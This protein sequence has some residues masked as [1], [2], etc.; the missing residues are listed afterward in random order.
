MRLTTA[1]LWDPAPGTLLRW[2]VH[3]DGPGVPATLS[4]NQRNHLSAAGAGAPSVWLA[5]AFDVDGPIDPVAL[6]RALQAFV[7]R[8]GS[9]QLEA[10]PAD[11]GAGA[12]RHDPDT[13]RWTPVDG[14]ATTTV[15]QT[16][17]LLGDV[18][19]AGCHPFGH[20]AFVPAA[21][22]RA[23]RSTIV[24]GMDHLHC[25]AYSLTIVVEELSAL[26]DAH[27]RGTPVE[28]PQAACVPAD[29]GR[30]ARTPV[31]TDRDRLARWHDAL[32]RNEFRLPTFPL[33]LGVAPGERLAQAT[34]VRPLADAGVT[35][36]LSARARA[37]GAS[38]Y[39]VC[40]VALAAALREA[41]GP[42]RLET[43]A[44]AHTR[45]DPAMRRAVG[46]YTT[47]VPIGVGSE[48]TEETIAAA[49]AAVREAV[50]LAA[51]PLDRVL[52]SV[53]QPLVQTRADVFMV[54]WLD[55]RHLPGAELAGRRNA[56]HV[57]ATTLADDVQ[58]WLAR[59]ADGVAVRA[60]MPETPTARDTV[61]ALLERWAVLLREAGAGPVR[62]R[63]T[64]AS[65]GARA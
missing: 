60:R 14:P 55:Y 34:M 45:V 41:G 31:G 17:E 42:Q 49:G 6:L 44:P 4:L 10:V 7:G 27:R 36:G 52:G 13:L 25:D 38:V 33:P 28:L 9:L 5:A 48:L 30:G 59:T 57:S 26:Y 50:E 18:L 11:G 32:R 61:G 63:A 16:R 39:A 43:L 51:V 2:E 20:P 58:L 37:A 54:S 62:P 35:A 1:D 8:H 53:P 15:A 23:D 40:L 12:V 22:S 64:S 47:T 46:W 21:I 65:A 56:H 3:A 19:T 29:A 24:L